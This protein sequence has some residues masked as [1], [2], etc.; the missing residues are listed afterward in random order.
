MKPNIANVSLPFLLTFSYLN[1]IIFVN[2]SGNKT[3]IPLMA[4]VSG[5]ARK[6]TPGN[7]IEIQTIMTNSSSTNMNLCKF[8]VNF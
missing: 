3:A 7:W 8:C 5:S 6:A 4:V 1:L 2:Y